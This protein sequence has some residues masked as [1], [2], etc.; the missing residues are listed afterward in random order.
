M[1]MTTG[2][3]IKINKMFD[4]VK[5]INKH[6]DRLAGILENDKHFWNEVFHEHPKSHW[7][8]LVEVCEILQQEAEIA[9]YFEQFDNFN[10]NLD[11]IKKRLDT[12]LP[13]VKQ[14]PKEGY[15]IPI[16]KAAMDFKDIINN[17]L[18][19]PTKEYNK[20]P[21]APPPSDLKLTKT[22]VIGHKL[23]AKERN[24]ITHFNNLFDTE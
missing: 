3:R 4:W 6:W 21:A 7:A 18:G 2:Q 8:D 20:E 19:T 5:T 10:R 15:N 14:W 17:I 24:K 12:R 22:K 13:V 9:E 23:T 11:I 1:E 16:F